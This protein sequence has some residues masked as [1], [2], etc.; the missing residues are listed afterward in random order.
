MTSNPDK[1]LV[2]GPRK[3]GTS[4]LQSLLD[5]HPEILMTPGELKLKHLVHRGFLEPEERAS[6]YYR[7]GRSFFPED[8]SEV[9]ADE[10]LDRMFSTLS[11]SEA[12]DRFDAETYRKRSLEARDER[13][14]FPELI[15]R[16]FANFAEAARERTD[17]RYHGA[18][19]VGAGGRTRYILNYVNAHFDEARF[20]LI[21]RRPK[22]IL[23][24]ITRARRR[25][26]NPMKLRKF[27]REWFNTNRVIHHLGDPE[28][29]GSD[30][31]HVLF[32]EALVT[33]TAETMRDVADFLDVEFTDSLHEPTQLGVTSKVKTSSKDEK[34]VFSESA[35][36]W[37]RG[38]TYT[39]AW[40][41]R[42]FQDHLTPIVRSRFGQ[43]NTYGE[44]RDRT[45]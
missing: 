18:K 6:H 17:P 3:A 4:L 42:A 30:R 41:I 9:G 2:Y 27:L 16:D 35:E 24:S 12:E 21:L 23:S 8:L 26:G 1:L 25:D 15:D 38:L 10:L 36:D 28:L 19:E 37:T 32:Y 22:F 29:L 33:E 13:A 11:T 14:G 20:V 43:L 5:G 31:V 7:R 39:E 34:K 45:D 44:I 40:R